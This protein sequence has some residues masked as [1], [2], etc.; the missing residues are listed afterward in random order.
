MSGRQIGSR[1]EDYLAEEWKKGENNDK[2]QIV[3]YGGFEAPKFKRQSLKSR[4]RQVRQDEREER[5]SEVVLKLVKHF[6]QK[7]DSNN[8]GSFDEYKEHD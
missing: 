1:R 7:N 2:Q 5:K 3:L 6:D 8:S 4:A